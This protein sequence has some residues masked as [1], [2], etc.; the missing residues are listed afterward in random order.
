MR[1]RYRRNPGRSGAGGWLILLPV[2][3]LAAAAAVLGARLPEG[4]SQEPPAAISCQPADECP[5]SPLPAA[6]CDAGGSCVLGRESPGSLPPE[7][8]GRAAAVIEEPCGALLY[9]L[10]EHDRLAP[11]SLTKIVTALVAVDRARLSDIVTVRVDGAELSAKT[12]STVM[13]LEPGQRLSMQ[14]L[15][16]GL[17]LPSGNDAAIAIAEHVGGSVP[18][19]VTLMN[20][21]VA[22]LGLGNT[23]FTNPHGLDDPGLYTSAYDIGMLGRELM[24]NP[25]L[26]AMVRTRKHQ[27][28]WDGPA[29]WNGNRLLTLYP[30]AIGVKIGYT[31]EANQTIVAAAEREGRRLIVSVLGSSQVYEDAIA[32][33]EWAFS[34]LPPQ[35]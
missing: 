24:R 11:A 3:L 6:A 33:F 31:D 4:Q 25:L 15:L 8:S 10:N 1:Y 32:L 23:N 26:A 28:P 16:Y 20:R 12:D 17:L 27:P 35:C 9:G 22:E 21:K 13:G 5:Q 19:F 2:V 29:L 30:E 7:T 18:A 34:E 14:D